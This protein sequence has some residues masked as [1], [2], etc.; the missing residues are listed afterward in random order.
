M[1]NYLHLKKKAVVYL[2][3]RD[4]VTCTD[5]THFYYTTNWGTTC[6]N[7]FKLFPQVVKS[8]IVILAA[9]TLM[10]VWLFQYN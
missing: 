10:E 7:M 1:A 4:N 8:K 3:F 9:L 5:N 2:L 6:L